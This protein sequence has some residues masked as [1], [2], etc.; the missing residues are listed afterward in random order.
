[1]IE[2]LFIA[3]KAENNE[4]KMINPAKNEKAIT[5]RL[6][7]EGNQLLLQGASKLFTEPSERLA[8]LEDIKNY[9]QT[10]PADDKEYR[11][12]WK[13]LF[14]SKNLP[15]QQKL[16]VTDHRSVGCR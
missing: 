13:A 12:I 8:C 16:Y 9:I 3:L 7:S 1:M 5:K 14:Y 10:A 15:F 4:L 6:L 2:D 11:K